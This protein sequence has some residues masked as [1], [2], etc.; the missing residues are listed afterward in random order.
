M[1][2]TVKGS[3]VFAIDNNKL[4]AVNRK[5]EQRQFV[6][7]KDNDDLKLFENYND[8]LNYAENTY[9]NRVKQMLMNNI[10]TPQDLLMFCVNY[11]RYFEE[12]NYHIEV[13]LAKSKQ[14][15]F[16]IKDKET[17]LNDL[18]KDTLYPYNCI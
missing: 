3:E 10:K 11:G 6:E 16:E 5:G 1:I 14:F 15:G 4:Y 18:K 12:E 9:E 7:N 8:A 13:L 2:Y 17:F